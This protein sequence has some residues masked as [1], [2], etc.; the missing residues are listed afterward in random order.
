MCILQNQQVYGIDKHE[1]ILLLKSWT[2]F[3]NVP[4]VNPFE[5]KVK[6]DP[7]KRTTKIFKKWKFQNVLIAHF[8]NAAEFKLEVTWKK[9]MLQI[10]VHAIGGG[11]FECKTSSKEIRHRDSICMKT[12]F[13]CVSERFHI[14]RFF[15]R[16]SNHMTNPNFIASGKSRHFKLIFAIMIFIFNKNPRHVTHEVW[17]NSYTYLCCMV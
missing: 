1:V 13:K 11:K 12:K 10:L 6:I 15:V 14:S 2:T 7:G 4:S 8:R 16:T 3:V 9:F 17:Y 5:T